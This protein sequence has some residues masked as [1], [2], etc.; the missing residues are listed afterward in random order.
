M[1]LHP[2]LATCCHCLLCQPVRIGKRAECLAIT[3]RQPHFTG[4][5]P[6]RYH[7]FHGGLEHIAARFGFI[8]G[9][10]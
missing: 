10:R 9:A 8:C 5:M 2:D 1:K 7:L 3:Q 6:I 4:V